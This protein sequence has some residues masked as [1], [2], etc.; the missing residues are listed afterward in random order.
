MQIA[1]NFNKFCPKSIKSLSLFGGGSLYEQQ[2]SCN[3][4]VDVVI[5][6]PGRIIDLVKKNVLFLHRVTYLVFDEAD[7]MLNM[8]FGEQVKSISKSVR[9][10]RQS[11][12][13]Y[14]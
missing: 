1:S 13:F 8:G 7:K 2:K 6:T 14:L 10:D 11:N 3:Q 5:G 9:P 12:S 4:E